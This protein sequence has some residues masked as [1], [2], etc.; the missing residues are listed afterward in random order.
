MVVFRTTVGPP[1]GPPY[2]PSTLP[3]GAAAAFDPSTGVWTRLAR[4]PVQ[5]FAN[6]SVAWTG[7]QL[8]VVTMD[9]ESGNTPEVHVL[10]REPAPA[11]R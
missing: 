1:S 10:S 2:V 3:A 9:G 11:V 5:D 7:Q 8:I 6:A 4:C